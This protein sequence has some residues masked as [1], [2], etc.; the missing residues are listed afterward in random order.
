MNEALMTIG[1]FA[2][3]LGSDIQIKGAPGIKFSS[4]SFDSR[5]VRPNGLFFAIEGERDGHE[6]V[7][8][9]SDAGAAAAVV[10]HFVPVSLPQV[11]VKEHARSA[12]GLR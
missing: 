7:Q 5:S 2:E 4:V 12:A 6:F 1:E 11:L 9:A 8:A 3:M 10:T